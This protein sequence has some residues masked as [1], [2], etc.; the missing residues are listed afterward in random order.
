MKTISYTFY[1]RSEWAG[2]ELCAGE[3]DKVQ[4]PD[5]ATGL[6]CLAVRNKLGNWCGYVG[7][8]P[9][10]PLHGIGYNDERTWPLECHGGLTFSDSCQHTPDNHGIYHIPGDNE[11]DDVWWFGFDCAHAGDLI[12][13]M[14]VYFEA[15]HKKASRGDVYRTLDYVK[16]QCRSLA[17]Q[18]SAAG[19]LSPKEF[20]AYTKYNSRS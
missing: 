3:P 10:H 7:V 19:I 17:R 20:R 9:G 11:P 16:N 18:L 14:P 6:P 8:P 2:K 15:L 5:P 12:P 1:D 4:F 13:S